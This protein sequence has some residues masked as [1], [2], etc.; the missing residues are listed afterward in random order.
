MPRSI[1]SR[2]SVTQQ[3]TETPIH[4]LNAAIQNHQ[5]NAQRSFLKHPAKAFFACSRKAVSACLRSVMSL[6]ISVTPMT[7]PSTLTGP[8]RVSY[9]DTVPCGPVALAH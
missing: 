4:T 7:C 1:T 9:Q 6:E 5:D 8:S 3:I 2:V